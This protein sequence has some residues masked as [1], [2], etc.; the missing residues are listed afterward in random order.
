[1]TP[2]HTARSDLLVGRVAVITGA[3]SGIGRAT[4]QAFAACGA[5]A[6]V[7]AD[8]RSDPR[9]GGRSTV[10][11]V[12]DAGAAAQF[13]ETDVTRPADLMAAV[14]VAESLGG[15]TTM[16]NCAGIFR[17]EDFFDVT[18][19]SYD[20]M[21]AINV[22]GTFF[23]CQAAA[24]AMRH[25]GGAIV[26]LASVASYRGSVGHATYHATKGAVQALTYA[27][28]RD[29][30]QFGIRVNAVHPGAVDT[31]MLRVDDPVLPTLD[32]ATAF[33]LGRPASVDDIANAVVYLASDLATYVSGASLT[34]D[35]AT[36]SSG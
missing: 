35:G 24:K 33:P 20:A 17:R 11:L 22:R 18:E 30:A 16:V 15:L 27:L 10:E 32:V 1:M 12:Q 3:A 25:R 23:G 13:V 36:G 6:V 9:E 28:A 31:W 4:A 26:N 2:P 8:V 7:V 29:L 14:G 5:A 19:E 21:L 34:V